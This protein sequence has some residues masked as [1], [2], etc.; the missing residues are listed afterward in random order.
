MS[1]SLTR[2]HGLENEVWL[3]RN[4]GFSIFESTTMGGT[5]GHFFL[6]G[7]HVTPQDVKA[8][9]RQ[10]EQRAK[11][12]FNSPAPIE[13]HRDPPP[14]A[15]EIF[16]SAPLTLSSCRGSQARPIATTPK[17][18]PAVTD[19]FR[20]LTEAEIRADMALLAEEWGSHTAAAKAA[21]VEKSRWN[22]VRHAVRIGADIMLALYGPEGTTLRAEIRAPQ[23]EDEQPPAEAPAPIPAGDAAPAAGDPPP[24][25]TVSAEA[26]KAAPEIDEPAAEPT[27]TMDD[28]AAALGDA[29]PANPMIAAQLQAWGVGAQEGKAPDRLAAVFDMAQAEIA[30]QLQLIDGELEAL[31]DERRTLE[32]EADK[33]RKAAAALADLAK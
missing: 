15:A 32:S 2:L 9:A 20:G 12:G 33:L 25:A 18:E 23:G 16:K 6:K 19:L 5:D 13:L 8:F 31:D 29:G 24:P 28:M 30:R 14:P 10:L 21:G 11:A 27:C 22:N 7:K 4:R 26:P 3:I 17:E 1:G